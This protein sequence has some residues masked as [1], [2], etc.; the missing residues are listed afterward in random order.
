MMGLVLGAALV[1]AFL[2]PI[3]PFV[4]HVCTL[5][6]APDYESLSFL[7]FNVGMVYFSGGFHWMSQGFTFCV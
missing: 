4:A 1:F 5:N 6:A 7:V 2:V 3:I